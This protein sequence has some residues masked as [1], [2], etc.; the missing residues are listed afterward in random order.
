LC[1]Q[2]GSEFPVAA[3]GPRLRRTQ[4][5]GVTDMPTMG[6]LR[7]FPAI[8]PADVASPRGKMPPSDATIQY[9][10]PSGVGALPTIDPTPDL[11]ARD[12]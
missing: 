10:L 1:D 6:A 2:L 12:P 5:N 8:E 11:P 9:P 7:G 3:R 4:V